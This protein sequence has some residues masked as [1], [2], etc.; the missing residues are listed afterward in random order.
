MAKGV[1]SGPLWS[2][3]LLFQHRGLKEERGLASQGGGAGRAGT[4]RRES[5]ARHQWLEQAVN[6]STR[7]QQPREEEW[8]KY[9]TCYGTGDSYGNQGIYPEVSETQRCIYT[10]KEAKKETNPEDI[11]D[12]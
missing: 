10:E 7:R 3:A 1:S 11:Y 12:N 9:R 8:F 5:R 4:E 6:W 2:Y